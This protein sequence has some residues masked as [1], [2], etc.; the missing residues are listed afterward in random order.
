MQSKFLYESSQDKI[1]RLN[2]SGTS[3]LQPLRNALLELLGEYRKFCQFPDKSK[4]IGAVDVFHYNSLTIIATYYPNNQITAYGDKR[5]L[6]EVK[7]TLITR[8][9]KA[10]VH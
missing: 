10:E 9:K 5:K 3:T 7:E 2:G 6:Q 8:L 1:Y 4:G